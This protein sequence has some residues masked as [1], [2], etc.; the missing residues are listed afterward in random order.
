M[1]LV[2]EDLQQLT[3]L[4]VEAARGAGALVGSYLGTEMVVNRKA[5]GSLASQVVTEVDALVQTLILNTLAPAT[6]QYD[7]AILAEEGEDDGSRFERP[8]FWC[9]DPID[10]TLPFIEGGPGCAVSIA[11]VSQSGRPLIGV[12]F[13]PC[14]QTLYRATQG[15]GAWRNNEPWS[16]PAAAPAFTLVCDRSFLD[17][18]N[19]EQTVTDVAEIAAELGY[20]GVELIAHGGGVMNACW[21]IEH[22]PACY[23]KGPRP[24]KSGGSIWDYAATACLYQELGAV[25]TDADG[26]PLELNRRESTYLNHRGLIFASS[27][28]LG[29]RLRSVLA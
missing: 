3:E 26:S 17:Y 8:Y 20:D 29:I 18:S 15:H 1:T 10:G 13:D 22:A 9:I 2:P 28:E 27:A 14:T 4:A 7:L 19:Y 21:V 24:G 25:C 5:G 12:V 16:V 11:L 6:E 23:L